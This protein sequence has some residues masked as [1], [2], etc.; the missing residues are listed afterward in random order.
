MLV[1]LLRNGKYCGNKNRF[2]NNYSHLLFLSIK[3][4]ERLIRKGKMNS[5]WNGWNELKIWIKYDKIKKYGTSRKTF[6]NLSFPYLFSFIKNF[7]SGINWS[8]FDFSILCFI[9]IGFVNAM[10]LFYGI[11]MSVCNYFCEYIFLPQGIYLCLIL[12]MRV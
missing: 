6:I 7:W 1:F 3:F 10:F 2:K 8:C 11:R 5:C 9:F 4:R 12:A